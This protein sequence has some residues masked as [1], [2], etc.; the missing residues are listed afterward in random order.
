MNIINT[1]ILM[2]SKPTETSSL[3]IECLFGETIEIL[4]EYLDWVYCKLNTESYHGW[5][6]KE[7]LGKPTKP[8]SNQ[9]HLT[10]FLYHSPNVSSYGLLILSFL[11]LLFFNME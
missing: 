6:K 9:S 10:S 8:D 5:V 4:D 11:I 3:E 1:S 7:G 2:K